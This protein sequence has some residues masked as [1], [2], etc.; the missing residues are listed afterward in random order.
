MLRRPPRSTLF[1]ST[2]LFRPPAAPRFSPTA[3]LRFPFDARKRAGRDPVDED[4]PD[5]EPRGPGAGE[6]PRRTVPL[7]DHRH[8]HSVRAGREPPHYIHAARDTPHVPVA[9]LTQRPVDGHLR[10][11]PGGITQ[12][13]EGA[14]RR[15]LDETPAVAALHEP[16]PAIVRQ[17]L[18]PPLD[19]GRDLK[20]AVRRRVDRGSINGAHGHR[21]PAPAPTR[22]RCGS[23]DGTSLRPARR[24]AAGRPPTP[25]GDNVI[26]S[27]AAAATAARGMSPS[28]VPMSNR[29][30]VSRFPVPVSRPRRSKKGSSSRTTARVPPNSAFKR[31]ISRSSFPTATG[32]ARGSSS[33]SLPI[34]GSPH[35]PSPP[36]H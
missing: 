26:P 25:M 3:L 8:L 7:V 14:H 20:D 23:R 32:S 24:A 27:R 28:P 9:D 31:A 30:H 34:I 33:S 17:D 29:V 12:R 35:P 2:P 13:A 10:H 22:P 36:P 6:R 18:R 15:H 5:H 1:P 4:R 21:G 16:H 11:P 19:V